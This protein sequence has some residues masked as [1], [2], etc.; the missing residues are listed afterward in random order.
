MSGALPSAASLYRRVWRVIPPAEWAAFSHD[1]EAI[2][3]LKRERN[4]VIL[5][6]NYQTPEI[7]HCVADIV[8]DSLALARKAM[9]VDADV[10]VLAGVHFMAETAKLLNPDKTVLIP[11]LG[12]GCSLADSITADDVRLM[13]QRY[14]GVPVVTY[15]NTSAAVK[16]E[17]DICCTSGNALAVVESLGAP[18]VIMLP[19]EYLA[20]NIAAQTEVEIIAWQ[21]HCEVHER[22]GPADIRE[23]RDAYPG[24]TVLAHPEC[25]PEV[26]AVADFAGSTAAMSDYVGRHK[27]ARVVLMTECSMSDNVAV[28]H[29]EVE[30]VRPCNLCPHMKR[31]TLANIRA[32]LEQDRYVVTIDPDVTDR[33]RR[34]VERMLVV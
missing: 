4:A 23:L 15:V 21:G 17:S 26:V 22:F 25:P 1:V 10:I 11:D 6:H 29:P 3:A 30:F 13:R 14:P 8:G 9:T 5:A 31:I 28:E 16:A 24:V 34:V 19:D 12:A 20:G 7:F 27:P 2:L 18:R 32:A 33:A